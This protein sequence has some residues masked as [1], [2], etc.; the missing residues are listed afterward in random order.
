MV[1]EV[2]EGT[3]GSSMAT[4]AQ[5]RARKTRQIRTRGDHVPIRLLELWRRTSRYEEDRPHRVHLRIW[6]L[7]LGE[8]DGSDA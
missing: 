8:L 1:M 5:R 7:P 4:R 3:E 6:R 2:A